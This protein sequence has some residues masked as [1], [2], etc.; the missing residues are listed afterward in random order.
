VQRLPTA[1]FA[2]S[3]APRP[4]RNIRHFRLKGS[5]R[6]EKDISIVVQKEEQKMRWALVA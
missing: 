2:A 6:K 5:L 4:D 3:P 1:L